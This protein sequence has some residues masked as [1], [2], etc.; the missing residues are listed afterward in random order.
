MS[1]RIGRNDDL[2]VINLIQNSTLS[3]QNLDFG[4]RFVFFVILL[5]DRI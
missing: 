3:I 4:Q 5:T 2:L 1:F